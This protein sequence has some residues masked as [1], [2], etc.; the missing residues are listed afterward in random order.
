MAYKLYLNKATK[1]NI[2]I[3]PVDWLKATK[4]AIPSVNKDVKKL[5]ISYLP[6]GM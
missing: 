4:L 5:E 2:Y 1:K 3:R 6:E